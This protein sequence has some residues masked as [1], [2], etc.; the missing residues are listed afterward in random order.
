MRRKIYTSEQ[1]KS[2]LLDIFKGAAEAEADTMPLEPYVMPY[3]T[4]AEL[5]DDLAAFDYEQPTFAVPGLDQALVGIEE[6]V[7]ML[8][9]EY[10][11]EESEPE[12]LDMV[13][14]LALITN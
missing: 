3:E 14:L 12:P 8:I 4:K 1:A 10:N 13:G 7:K 2:H 6:E 9:A 11:L 5:D